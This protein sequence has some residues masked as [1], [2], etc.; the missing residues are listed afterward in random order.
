VAEAVRENAVGASL[1]SDWWNYKV[2]VQD[3]IPYAGPIMHDVGVVVSYNSD[4]DELARRLNV[5]AAKAV[6]YSGGR[7][8]PEVALKVVTINPAIQL[9]IADR[10]GTPEPGKHAD[11]AGWSGPALSA[12]TR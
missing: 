9:G 5:E 2:E 4:S 7:I 11:L 6:K 10:V 8:T 3:A 1:F 12:L